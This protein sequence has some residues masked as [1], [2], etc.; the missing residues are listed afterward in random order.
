MVSP[1]RLHSSEYSWVCTGSWWSL[2]CRT[3]TWRGAPWTSARPSP[4]WWGSRPAGGST[5]A[6]LLLVVFCTWHWG[7]R[8]CS[9]PRTEG[10]HSD[11]QNSAP[12]PLWSGVCLLIVLDNFHWCW[13][14]NNKMV[15]WSHCLC[16]SRTQNQSQSQE[17]ILSEHKLLLTAKE[18]FY[19][20]FW[21]RP[22]QKEIN[23]NLNQIH[24]VTAITCVVNS[25]KS[26]F[27]R[28]KDT[29]LKLLLCS[30]WSG[31]YDSVLSWSWYCIYSIVYCSKMIWS[32][33][34]L[35]PQSDEWR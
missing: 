31:F 26:S 6:P 11:P 12:P 18:Q 10:A 15:F 3:R 19:Q 29:M 2:R 7:G 35:H 27:I 23:D 8:G 28:V 34:N 22:A 21:S 5:L 20:V 17:W 9:S 13:R 32:L 16:S 25:S 30:S 24:Q 14:W 1:P 33:L 4:G